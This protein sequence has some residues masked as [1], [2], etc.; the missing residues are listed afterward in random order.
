MANMRLT[1]LSL[2]DNWPGIANLNLGIPTDGWDNTVENFNT[3]DDT[4]KALVPPIPIGQKRTIYT[5]NIHAPGT[6]TMMYL[7][8]NDPSAVDI[9]GDFSDGPPFCGHSDGTHGTAFGDGSTPPYWLVARCYSAAYW[10]AT[11]GLPVALPCS[12]SIGGDSSVSSSS[13]NDNAADGFGH[14]FGWFWVGGV[15]PVNDVTLFT[16][17]TLGETSGGRGVD[18]TCQQFTPGPIIIEVSTA[19]QIMLSAEISNYADTII[20]DN[21]NGGN[22]FIHGY[23]DMSAH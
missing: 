21:S 20:A 1:H 12:T 17:L 22:M 9:S 16:D 15:C 11:K 19:A 18:I 2:E 7:G 13:G 6:Y 5:D 3:A 23:V 14:G 4:A 10:D 8:Y